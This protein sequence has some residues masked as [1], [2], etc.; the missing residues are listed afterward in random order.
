MTEVR[1]MSTKQLEKT[2]TADEAVTILGV[3]RP[4]L[5]RWEQ[6]GRVKLSR[7]IVDKRLRYSRKEIEKLVGQTKPYDGKGIDVSEASRI[8]GVP[9]QTVRRMEARGL[10]DAT[11]TAGGYRVFDPVQVRQLKRDNPEE[12]Q[13]RR[14]NQA[15]EKDFMKGKVT[16]A[17]AQDMLRV[18]RSTL[19]RWEREGKIVAH[20]IRRNK[21][22]V[23]DRDSIEALALQIFGAEPEAEA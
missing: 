1:L 16:S 7:I 6:E 8:L 3:S 9:P 20:S 18:S 10:L 15:E 14:A 12:L 17:E 21:H 13:R 22:V 4:T 19:R 23:Y 5:L 11:R 2:V